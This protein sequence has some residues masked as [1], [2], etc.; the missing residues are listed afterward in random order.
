MIR[1]KDWQCDIVKNKYFNGRTAISLVSSIDGDDVCK[2]EPIATATVNIPDVALSPDEVIIKNY[3][4]NEGVLD[5][6]LK[7]GIVELSGRTIKSGF[8]TMPICILK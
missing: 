7:A 8:V 1:F 4:E 2:G 5:V 6:L 3:S